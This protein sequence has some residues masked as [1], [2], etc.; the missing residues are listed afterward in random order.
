MSLLLQVGTSDGLRF[1]LRWAD[2]PLATTAADATRGDLR[3]AFADDVIWGSLNGDGIDW[4]WIEILE[5]LADNW[6]Y[7]LFE[8]EVGLRLVDGHHDEAYLDMLDSHNLARG[9]Q[10]IWLPELYIFKSGNLARIQTSSAGYW[11]EWELALRCLSDLAGAIAERLSVQGAMDDMRAQLAC[12]RWN[13]RANIDARDATAIYLGVTRAELAE[14]EDKTSTDLVPE[15]QIFEPSH[16]LAAARFAYGS[17]YGDDWEILLTAVSSACEQ[18]QPYS[19]V[20]DEL[21]D[22]ALGQLSGLFDARPHEA[23]YAVATAIRDFLPTVSDS[24]TPISMFNVLRELHV[25]VKEISLRSSSLDGLA[26]WSTPNSATFFINTAG[27]HSRGQRG[28]NATLAHELCH[29][30]LDRTGALPLAEVN[31]GRVPEVVE[32]RARAFAANLLVPPDVVHHYLTTFTDARKLVDTV[33]RR[34]LAS[35]EVVAWQF[36]NQAHQ[37]PYDL[38]VHLLGLVRSQNGPSS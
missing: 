7:L 9:L 38:R 32:K 29:L 13:E 28:R 12:A 23:G 25:P 31:G 35:G 26:I 6:P 3:C 24:L 17:V 22:R 14:I 30:L 36:L 16:V 1:E 18:V 34:Y 15:G 4:T 8:E 19:P 33:S 37:L 2:A 10:G 27:K 20:V 11:T 21:V 5:Y